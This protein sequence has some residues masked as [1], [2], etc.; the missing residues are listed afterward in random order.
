MTDGC[1]KAGI[2]ENQLPYWIP[3]PRLKLA[4]TGFGGMT[5]RWL[6]VMLSSSNQ[7]L[8]AGAYVLSVI[9]Q[10]SRRDSLQRERISR[11][12]RTLLLVLRRSTQ[13]KMSPALACRSE[14]APPNPKKRQGGLHP[15]FWSPICIQFTLWT[16]FYTSSWPY[17]QVHRPGGASWQVPVPPE[18]RW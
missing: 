16:S 18:L 5:R 14:G 17:P 3:A 4:G 9:L 7:I 2:Q 10:S 8:L 6:G 1:S 13:T 15:A 11:A 12:A